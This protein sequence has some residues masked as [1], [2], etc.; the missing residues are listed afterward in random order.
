MQ[1]YEEFGVPFFQEHTRALTESGDRKLRAGGNHLVRQL[2]R[3][4]R[5]P[6]AETNRR[7]RKL[8]DELTSRG[9]MQNGGQVDIETY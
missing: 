8:R 3:Y 2:G 4:L 9:S 6:R 7:M 1:I 5:Q